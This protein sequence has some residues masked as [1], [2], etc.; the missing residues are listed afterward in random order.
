MSLHPDL[1]ERIIEP[2]RGGFS[3]EHA[4]YVLS[5]D[6]TPEEH[7]RYAELAR[8]A[9]DGSLSPDEQAQIDDFLAVNAVL[10]VLQSKARVS[11]TQHNSAA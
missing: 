11:L 3:E 4:R 10:S 8:K 9:Q 2:Q 1:F 7:T 6:F 5:L